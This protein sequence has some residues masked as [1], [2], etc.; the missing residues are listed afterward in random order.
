M[1]S[2]SM[3]D[4]DYH[5]SRFGDIS[6]EYKLNYYEY[7]STTNR[8]Y[9]L[10]DGALSSEDGSLVK[11]RISKSHF[12]EIGSKALNDISDNESKRKCTKTKEEPQC[13]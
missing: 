2:R 9:I 7:D 3:H 1:R 13:K 6:I 5:V 11:K 12:E 8:Y 10:I 4:G